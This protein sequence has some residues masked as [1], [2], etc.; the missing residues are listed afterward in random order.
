MGNYYILGTSLIPLKN[1]RHRDTIKSN[2][3]SHSSRVPF[4]PDCTMSTAI[5]QAFGQD[6]GLRQKI[7]NAI[8]TQAYTE[9]PLPSKD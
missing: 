4:K 3:L 1:P 8:R 5:D 2:T 7:H 9:P 6:N